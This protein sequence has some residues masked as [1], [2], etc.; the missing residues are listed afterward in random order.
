M[1]YHRLNGFNNRD[2]FLRVLEAGKSTVKVPANSVPNES[3]LLGLQMPASLLYPH[4]DVPLH[5]SSY[6]GHLFH[7]EVPTPMT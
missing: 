5:Y 4:I 1:K 2:V 3:S 6:K 7:H